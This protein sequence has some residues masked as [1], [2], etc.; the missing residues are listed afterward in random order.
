MSCI[1]SS[2]HTMLASPS[3]TSLPSHT[4]GHCHCGKTRYRLR[5]T[6][7]ESDLAL[8]GYCHCSK[9]QRLNGAPFVWTTHWEGGAVEW[10]EPEPDRTD[11]DSPNGWMMRRAADVLTEGDALVIPLKPDQPVVPTAKFASTMT[12]FESM[13]GRKWKQRCS[14]CGTPMGSWNEAKRR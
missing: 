11:F 2:D 9:C 4:T 1:F 3:S 8:S 13:E 6:D 12:I 10:L 5:L 7:I 14:T